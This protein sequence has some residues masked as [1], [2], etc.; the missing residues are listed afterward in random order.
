M[1]V[2]DGIDKLT[3]PG[4]SQSTHALDEN[5]KRNRGEKKPLRG[6]RK[7]KDHKHIQDLKEGK[8]GLKSMTEFEKVGNSH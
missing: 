4:K 7:K 6:R 2:D 8:V 1:Y 5:N 3:I